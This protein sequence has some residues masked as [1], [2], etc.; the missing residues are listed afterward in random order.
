MQTG[1]FAEGDR[2]RIKDVVTICPELR[3]KA[4]TIKNFFAKA[5]SCIVMLDDTKKI[6]LVYC[7]Q[8]NRI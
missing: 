4:G 8:I 7:D 2:V 6:H 1:R 5:G 3:G